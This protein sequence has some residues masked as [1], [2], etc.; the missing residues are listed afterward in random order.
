M[1][2]LNFRG[3]FMLSLRVNRKAKMI[4]EELECDWSKVRAEGRFHSIT[5]GAG[6]QD[7]GAVHLLE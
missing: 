3:H 2:Q 7:S 6:H 4:V 1:R 5:P